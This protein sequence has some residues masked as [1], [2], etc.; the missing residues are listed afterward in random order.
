M[1]SMEELD[2]AKDRV[3]YLGENEICLRRTTNEKRTFKINL[4][5]NH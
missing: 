2:Q 4:D 5:T 3:A 1:Q